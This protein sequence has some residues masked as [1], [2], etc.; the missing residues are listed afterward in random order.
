MPRPLI[1]GAGPS[2]LTAAI[3]LARR[4]IEPRI[5]DRAPDFAT[6]SRAI[7]INPRTLQILEPCGATERLLD[8]GTR[9]E[10]SNLRFPGGRTA[11]IDITR[12]RGPYPFMLALPQ[13]RTER[14]LGEILA[15]LGVDV[16]HNTAFVA[17]SQRGQLLECRLETHGNDHPDVSTVDTP[18][19]IGADGAHS[20]VRDAAGIT[21]PGD[22]MAEAWT[23]ADVRLDWPYPA[24]E[25]NI[26]FTPDGFLFAITLGEGTW[27]FVSDKGHPEA[28]LPKGARVT[29]TLWQS[30]FR[31]THRQAPSFQRG[32]VFLAGDAAHVHSPL[33]ARGMNMGIADAATLAWLMSEGR[34]SEYHARRYKVVK[35]TIA[36][37]KRQTYQA[38]DSGPFRLNLGRLIGPVALKIG[39]INDVAVRFVTGLS[40]PPAPWLSGTQDFAPHR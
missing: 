9:I 2:G 7:G 10:R 25:L 22:E 6:E 12:A 17:C 1:V 3:E 38:A 20:V 8:E 29:E 14:I 36:M 18:L 32:Q 15:D 24:N 34:E 28:L 19:L 23:L 4:G 5:I 26:F 31:V 27:R 11:T 30:S 39:L 37:V 13:R 21:F 35:R 40:D 33:G 16:E